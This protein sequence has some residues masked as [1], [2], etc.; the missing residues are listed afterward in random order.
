MSWDL[1]KKDMTQASSGGIR[2]YKISE[3]GTSHWGQRWKEVVSSFYPAKRLER[4]LRYAKGGQVLSIRIEQ[5]FATA[6]VQG[7][8]TQPYKVEIGLPMF[9]RKQWQRITAELL[10][11]AFYTAKLLAGDMP[12]DI[13]R[14]FQAAGAPLLP[15]SDEDISSDCS[16]TDLENPCKHVMAVYFILGQEIDRNP[17]LLMEMRGLTRAQLLT[18]IQTNRI[19][20]TKSSTTP[21]T[22]SAINRPSQTFLADRLNDF[23]SVPKNHSLTP[24]VDTDTLAQLR[25]PGSRIKE[26]GTPPFWQSDNNFE[27]VLIRIYQAVRKRALG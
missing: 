20:K 26:M 27:E 7:S 5:G 8:R 24:T 6:D 17:F 4:G 3:K 25:A 11:K 19:K 21:P 13:E 10:K 14:I 2:L 1:S 15:T 16:C 23:F 9:T 12:S 18:E 22:T